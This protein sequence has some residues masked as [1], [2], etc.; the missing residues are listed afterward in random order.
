MGSNILIKGK[1]FSELAA[2]NTVLVENRPATVKKAS[3]EELEVSLPNSVCSGRFRLQVATAGARSNVFPLTVLGKPEVQGSD[4]SGVAPGG[5]LTIHG[6]NFCKTTNKNEVMFSI[7]GYNYPGTVTAATTD[8][9]T[10]TVPMFPELKNLT[11]GGYQSPG[12]VNVTVCG[13]PAG[14]LSISLGRPFE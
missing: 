4:L 3:P 14:S 5:T 11:D 2:K 7:S 6:K 1:G 9:I 13:T 12:Q 8:T 10:V